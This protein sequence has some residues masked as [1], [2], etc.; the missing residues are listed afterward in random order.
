MVQAGHRH[1]RP[2]GGFGGG[3]GLDEWWRE[4]ERRKEIARAAL[5]KRI[6]FSRA[7][8]LDALSPGTPLSRQ[9]SHKG[10]GG[11][12]QS[13]PPGGVF[14]SKTERVLPVPFRLVSFRFVP[15][16]GRTEK[17]E[18]KKRKPAEKSDALQLKMVMKMV[19]MDCVYVCTRG[20]A[21]YGWRM[22]SLRRR[23]RLEERK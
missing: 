20:C 8:F 16:Q 3:G 10:P 4:L 18:M 21:I 14:P 6:T 2:G 9:A 5:R 11:E 13:A 15:R 17:A 7:A 12:R 1:A 23:G 19:T 22:P